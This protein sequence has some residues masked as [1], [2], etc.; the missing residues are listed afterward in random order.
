MVR[1]ADCGL[2]G[3]RNHE[4][5]EIDEAGSYFREEGYSPFYSRSGRNGSRHSPVPLCIAGVVVFKEGTGDHAYKYIR[6]QVNEDREC[7]SFMAWVRGR[8]PWE[9]EAMAEKRQQLKREDRRHRET[10]LVLGLGVII[11]TLAASVLNW[12]LR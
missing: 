2:L 10:L 12:L 3:L 6:S 1:C 4:T 7:R 9:H 11:A 5:D 8:Y